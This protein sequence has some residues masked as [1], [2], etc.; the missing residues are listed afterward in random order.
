MSDIDGVA[1]LE[2]L[3]E[4][5]QSLRIKRVDVST[6]TPT[7]NTTEPI[8]SC[9]TARIGRMWL[10]SRLSWTLPGFSTVISYLLIEPVVAD[11][12]GEADC[13]N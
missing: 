12:L 8:L 2:A 10:G 7:I 9:T 1:R 6:Y 13:V 11:T 3:T 4:K 5:L